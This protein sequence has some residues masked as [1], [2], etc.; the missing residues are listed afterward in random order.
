MG[1]AGRPRARYAIA[2]PLLTL[3]VGLSAMVVASP[4]RADFR[5]CNATQNLV[6]VGIGYIF[7]ALVSSVARTPA[8]RERGLFRP[9]AV[10]AM[11]A[12]PNAHRTNL[13]GSSLWQLGLLELWL[14][15]HVD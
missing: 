9:S 3:G 8:A 14:Q 11:L 6:G 12:D 5:V 1:S 2:M 10:E 15:R 13:D 7:A 4:A